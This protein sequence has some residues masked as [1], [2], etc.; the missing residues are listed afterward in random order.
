MLNIPIVHRQTLEVNQNK[1]SLFEKIEYKQQT[2]NFFLQNYKNTNSPLEVLIN[3]NQDGTFA[4]TVKNINYR[5]KQIIVS[6]NNKINFTSKRINSDAYQSVVITSKDLGNTLFK[7]VFT[8]SVALNAL[9]RMNVPKFNINFNQIKWV[10]I[11][12]LSIKMKKTQKSNNLLFIDE[13]GIIVESYSSFRFIQNIDNVT[14]KFSISR[15]RFIPIELI[16]GIHN[17]NILKIENLEKTNTPPLII[18]KT[19]EGLK[20]S[21]KQQNIKFEQQKRENIN[22]GVFA[23]IIF[24]ENTYYSLENDN[25]YIGIGE[26]SKK[27]Y[28]VPY[29]F[30]GD[31]FPLLK[32]NIGFAKDVVIGYSSKLHEP[33]FNKYSG[34]I[35]LK[36]TESKLLFNDLNEKITKIS[37]KNFSNIIL[38]NLTLE[39]IMVLNKNEE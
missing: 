22:E 9:T 33:Y 15:I 32:I 34:K 37:N 31:L 6:L 23:N 35:K 28:V 29:K 11:S 27:G 1:F 25:T 18:A 39:E 30:K 4:I 14:P 21:T 7:D 10:R 19:I 24:D 2:T 36:I 5:N 17:V 13:K 26:N 20:I 12:E 3:K 8:I 38:D 16:P